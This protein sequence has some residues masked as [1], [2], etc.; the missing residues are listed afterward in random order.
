MNVKYARARANILSI[1]PTYQPLD[2]IG[3]VIN[4]VPTSDTKFVEKEYYYQNPN[5]SYEFIPLV[6]NTDYEINDAISSFGQ[7]V[8]ERVYV[9]E[10]DD[11]N[12][13]VGK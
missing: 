3:S 1:H 12:S 11:W 13:T 10:K 9:I 7:T 8:Y 4:F 6:K 5:K 2:S